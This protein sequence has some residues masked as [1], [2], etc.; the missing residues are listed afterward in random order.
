MAL[1]PWY[2][3]VTPEKTLETGSPS[4]LRSLP[5]TWIRFGTAARQLITRIRSD[6]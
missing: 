5:F 3:V 2:K 1:K 4:M 6:S